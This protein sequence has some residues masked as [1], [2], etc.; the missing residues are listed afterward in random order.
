M[1]FAEQIL[2]EKE[3]K[4]YEFRWQLHEKYKINN[5][6]DV[7]NNIPIIGL[8]YKFPN[9]NL[10]KA[11]IFGQRLRKYNP[12][13]C[14]EKYYNPFWHL[15]HY[16]MAAEQMYHAGTALIRDNLELCAKEFKV[17]TELRREAYFRN[18][19]SIEM[20]LNTLRSSK[21]YKLEEVKFAF[22]DET[23]SE[24]IGQIYAKAIVTERKYIK[25][26][27][28]LNEASESIINSLIRQINKQDFRLKQLLI[29]RADKPIKK[30]ELIHKLLN[31]EDCLQ[32]LKRFF[33]LWDIPLDYET[34][35]DKRKS[36]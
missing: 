27:K 6:F 33:S 30:D 31:N 2:N 8:I 19:I 1:R 28:R 35:Y 22:Y 13:F 32:D 34:R 26:Y 5:R 4:E 12:Y 11:H 23:N 18:N 36:L 17:D 9:K 10:F 21:D 14:I 3:I 20:I 15:N 7:H 25:E 16:N 24:Y 29:Q